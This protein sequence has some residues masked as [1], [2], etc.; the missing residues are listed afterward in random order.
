MTGAH[1]SNI[2]FNLLKTLRFVM[3][4]LFAWTIASFT[5]IAQ[6]HTGEAATGTAVEE[7]KSRNETLVAELLPEFKVVLEGDELDPNLVSKGEDG[8]V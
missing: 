1:A 2:G 7:T 5:A 3:F 6:E 4:C 8:G